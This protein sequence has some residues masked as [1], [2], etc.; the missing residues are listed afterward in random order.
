MET[1]QDQA[2]K[3]GVGELKSFLVSNEDVLLTNLDSGKI[4][5]CNGFIPLIYGTLFD[6]TFVFASLRP[7]AFNPAVMH[8]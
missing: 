3:F 1:T 7:L 2:T 5:N 6:D 8:T 4:T